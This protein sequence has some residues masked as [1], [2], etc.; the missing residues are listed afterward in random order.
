MVS[1]ASRQLFSR[2]NYF[3]Y[4]LN[5]RLCELREYLARFEEENLT[6]LHQE[7]HHNFSF[8]LPFFD[9]T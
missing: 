1:S 2:R 5:M 4:S 7:S 8:L 9:V 6:C 3:L